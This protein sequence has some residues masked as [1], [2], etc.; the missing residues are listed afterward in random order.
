LLIHPVPPFGEEEEE[1]DNTVI[2]CDDGRIEAVGIDA[3]SGRRAGSRPFFSMKGDFAT[4]AQM[5][6]SA[7]APLHILL[8]LSNH[9]HIAAWE[10]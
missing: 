3:S 1:A 9:R 2:A 5:L 6:G 7:D 10:R 4:A 8:Q